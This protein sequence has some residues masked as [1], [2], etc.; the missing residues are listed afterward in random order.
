MKG[1]PQPNMNGMYYPQDQNGRSIS[2]ADT[3]DEVGYPRTNRLISEPP[4][5]GMLHPDENAVARPTKSPP[6]VLMPRPM[7]AIAPTR[8]LVLKNEYRK[9]N[10]PSPTP[11]QH[12][13]TPTPQPSATAAAAVET[14]HSCESDYGDAKES[15]FTPPSELEPSLT[16]A[17]N[18]EGKSD[19]SHHNR[20]EPLHLEG[21]LGFNTGGAHSSDAQHKK[22]ITFAGESSMH[23][24]PPASSSSKSTLDKPPQEPDFIF[25]QD[26]N[27]NTDI[28]R[29]SRRPSTVAANTNDSSNLAVPSTTNTTTTS[30]LSSL[31]S[32]TSSSLSSKQQIIHH[33]QP[34]YH[35]RPQLASPIHGDTKVASV[36]AQENN[37]L[38]KQLDQLI[39]E[40]DEQKQLE[41]E[42]KRRIDEMF[43]KVKELEGQLRRAL[44]TSALASSK[45]TPTSVTRQGPRP[46]PVQQTRPV[47]KVVTHGEI[48]HRVIPRTDELDEMS[49]LHYPPPP[50]TERP[51]RR[52]LITRPSSGNLRRVSVSQEPLERNRSGAAAAG[53]SRSRS[54]S[55]E[56]PT[57]RVTTVLP[58]EEIP[59][60]RRAPYSNR[61]PPPPVEPKSRRRGE[62]LESDSEYFSDDDYYDHYVR[63]PRHSTPGLYRRSS[64]D[65]NNAPLARRRSFGSYPRRG[66]HEVY[67]DDY[68][69]IYVARVAVR[70]P[71]TLRRR[72]SNKNLRHRDTYYEDHR[73]P[74]A[75]SSTQTR[76]HG[77]NTHYL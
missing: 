25:L 35:P 44:D 31:T 46:T 19:D 68:E 66:S 17:S 48:R 4:S 40:R 53:R 30:S 45:S 2:P 72:P 16:S 67:E 76:K 73:H 13:R 37:M 62:Y 57:H 21:I 38:R 24:S 65:R 33:P 41:D 27:N 43:D 47:K 51:R 18:S 49:P 6:P 34:Q 22:I 14:D 7:H 15:A 60:Y 1:N 52:S 3:L 71:N 77:T 59:Y 64:A 5:A 75:Y 42:H 8:N 58:D 12:R 69:R 10:T 26:N 56:P 70:E 36:I 55:R 54:R 29:S 61:P 50:A 23:V 39:L 63:T 32:S 74:R 20:P 9:P 28:M 11:P